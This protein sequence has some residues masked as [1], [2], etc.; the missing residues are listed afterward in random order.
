M[1]NKDSGLYSCGVP[2]LICLYP[3]DRLRGSGD[4]VRECNQYK[5][6]QRGASPCHLIC[7][8][9][10]KA[11]LEERATTRS[12]V[13][14]SRGGAGYQSQDSWLFSWQKFG[15]ALVLESRLVQTS[16]RYKISPHQQ[17]EHLPSSR[18]VAMTRTRTHDG[19]AQCCSLAAF[20][21]FIKG[22]LKERWP[23][24]VSLVGRLDPLCTA[25]FADCVSSASQG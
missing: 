15:D 21:V 7:R 10:A 9:R 22:A 11:S 14:S 13:A 25:H 3:T 2:Q 1:G 23:P 19:V 5:G 18:D 17:R 8:P 12:H 16:E 20:I 4:S 6:D 24:L